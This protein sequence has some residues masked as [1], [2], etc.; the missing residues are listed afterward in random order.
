[1][2]RNQLH[3]LEATG[4]FHTKGGIDPETG[5]GLS[6]PHWHQGA[7]ACEVEVDLETGKVTVV[8]YCGA[9]FAGRVVNPRLARLQN[10]G[11]VVFGMGPALLEEIVFDHG[12]IINP[13][14]SDY[15]IPSFLDVPRE[16]H[17]VSLESE[18]GE[19]H[20]IGE[21]TLPPVAPAIANAI[22]DAIGKRIYD[23]PITAEKV[24]KAVQNHE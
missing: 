24:L 3:S 16:L 7:G 21:M 4:E 2:R 18:L 1:M 20:G 5:Q 19:F 13:N 23:L 10:D 11:N 8:R 12:Q 22:F 14:L 15:M 6:T 17:T 9:S